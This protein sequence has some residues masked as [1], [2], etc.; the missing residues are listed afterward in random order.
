MKIKSMSP[1]TG[2]TQ[3]SD[4]KKGDME[5]HLYDALDRISN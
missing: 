4:L 3:M 2:S 5:T 1:Q